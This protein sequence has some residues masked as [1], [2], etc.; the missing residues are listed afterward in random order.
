[1]GNRAVITTK[2]GWE[3]PENNLG[4]YLHWNGGRDSVEPFLEYC[5]LKGFRSPDNDSYGWARMCQVIG[6]FFGGG[7]SIGINTVNRLDCDNWDSG[8]YIIENWSIVGRHCFEGLEQDSYDFKEMLVDIDKAQPIREQ[9]GT[10]FLT[11]DEVD[12]REISIGDKVFVSDFRGNYD[13]L[14]V[15]GIGEDKMVNGR[16]VLGVPYVARYGHNGDYSWNVN[17]Y[18]F[19]EAYRIAK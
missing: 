2:Q 7:L 5:K 11:A 14:E 6:N 1:M 3:N 19:D 17:N 18:L 13:E 4:V 16:N 8:V 15:V 9:L 10:R 12:A